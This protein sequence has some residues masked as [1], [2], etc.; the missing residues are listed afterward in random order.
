MSES[1]PGCECPRCDPYPKVLAE[2]DRYLRAIQEICVVSLDPELGQ[3][4]G[5]E[6]YEK[7]WL[8]CMEIAKQALSPSEQGERDT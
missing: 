4:I 7:A 3:I 6:H 1:C 5:S 2:R 8:D